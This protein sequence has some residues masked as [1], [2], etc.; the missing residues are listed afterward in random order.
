[1]ELISQLNVKY[2]YLYFYTDSIG[3]P[4]ENQSPAITWPFLLTE[5][6]EKT[7]KVKVYTYIRG[8]GGGT[9][10]E[11]EKIFDRD[12]GYLKPEGQHSISFS[13]FN[14]GVV[15]AA[16]RPFTYHLRLLARVPIIG[17]SCWAFISKILHKHKIVLSKLYSFNLTNPVKFKSSF[18]RMVAQSL[19]D[20]IIS[21]SIDTPLTP[22]ILEYR[23]P[24]LRKSIAFFNSIKHLNTSALHVS[25]DWVKDQHYVADGHHLN[26]LGH[27]KLAEHIYMRIERVLID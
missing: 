12:R 18:N 4:R 22:L 15:D 16:P 25:T 7:F 17:V 27:F 3:F 10:T 20:G 19:V 9:I 21:I 8:I 2:I 24:G 14:V 5:K 11:I 23:A 26:D 1:M 6:L 13:I